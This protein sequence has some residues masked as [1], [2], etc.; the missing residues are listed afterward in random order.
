MGATFNPTLAGNTVF[1][2]LSQPGV[3][4]FNA[5]NAQLFAGPRPA[6]PTVTSG[7]T[8]LSAVKA[9]PVG[10]WLVASNGVAALAAPV[11]FTA[12]AT[13][14]VSF[15]RFYYGS[16]TSPVL[17][18]DVGVLASGEK[19]IVS[20][21]SAVSGQTV[22]LTDLRFRVATSG[23]ACVSPSVANEIVNTWANNPTA[24]VSNSYG[25]LA[26]FSKYNLDTGLY[27]RTVTVE[28]WDGPIPANSS[29][30]P[31]GTKLW[32]KSI[33]GNELFG[34]SGLSAALMQNQTA[35]AI[36]SG[37]PTFVRATKAA[38]ASIPATSM[39]APFSA[40]NGVQFA[41]SAMVSGVSNTLT[42]FTVTFQA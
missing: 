26:G 1:N 35:N 30:T 39:Q 13:G 36:A 31:S 22:N 17:D 4:G 23:D 11:A 21:L 24:T 20:T 32:S 2:A 3:T 8:A 19:A 6:D 9:L 38:Y 18:V 40:L 5:S 41:N 10:T 37:T 7:I 33:S 34:V 28:A 29:A 12:T 14:T 27:D 42:N 16:G 15:V 25:A